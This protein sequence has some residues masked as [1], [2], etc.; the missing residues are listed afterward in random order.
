LLHVARIN[1]LRKGRR[2]HLQKSKTAKS[3][4]DIYGQKAVE[5]ILARNLARGAKVQ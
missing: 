1:F 5:I 2:L 3:S 4:D